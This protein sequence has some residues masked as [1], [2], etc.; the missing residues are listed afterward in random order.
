LF[1]QLFVLLFYLVLLT[2][3]LL[4]ILDVKILK[5][6]RTKDLRHYLTQHLL[7]SIFGFCA[8]LVIRFNFDLPLRTFCLNTSMFH[9]IHPPKFYISGKITHK[10]T[11][12]TKISKFACILVFFRSC[13]QKLN[14]LYG[15][16][17]MSNKQ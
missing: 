2:C 13:E 4:K 11:F 7:N 6:R 14:F 5:S 16:H 3:F 15:S 9:Q 12:K 10:L 8:K 1:L 17:S